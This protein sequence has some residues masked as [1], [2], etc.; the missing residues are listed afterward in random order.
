MNTLS[1]VLKQL[2][3]T[4]QL[5]KKTELSMNKVELAAIDD[6]D[7]QLKI[8]EDLFGESKS[9]RLLMEQAYKEAEVLDEQIDNLEGGI[10]GAEE[11]VQSANQNLNRFYSDQVSKEKDLKKQLQIR[12]DD[13]KILFDDLKDL[14]EEQN[15]V[16][17]DLNKDVRNSD[18]LES[19][20]NKTI[21]RTKSLLKE[22]A[23]AASDLGVKPNQ[24][25]A[26]VRGE[27]GIKEAEKELNVLKQAVK[28]AQ[29][30]L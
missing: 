29:R 4:E 19:S 20:F 12:K 5:V 13:L 1:R 25:P 6:I 7:A 17:N 8:L 16:L 14:Q 18:V 9:Q 26:Y 11:K 30:S 28:E 15:T 23:K 2:Q 24:L 10:N 27:N 22:I 3:K 21:A